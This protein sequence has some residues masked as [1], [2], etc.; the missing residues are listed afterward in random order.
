MSHAVIR[1]G[2]IGGTIS[3]EG[4]TDEDTTVDVLV[5]QIRGLGA[6]HRDVFQLAAREA[7]VTVRVRLP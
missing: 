5:V 6:I 1:S 4:S 2:A 3:S 7:L